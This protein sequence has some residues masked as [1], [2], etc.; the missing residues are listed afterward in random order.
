MEAAHQLVRVQVVAE[1]V[2]QL[3]AVAPLFERRHDRLDREALEA[4]QPAQR[5]LGLGLLDLQLALVGEH[6]PRHAGVLGARG[7]PLGAGLQ[8][9]QR[10]GVGV[11]ALALVHHRAHAV[12]G[13]GA[14]DEHHVA[15]LAQPRHA[16]AAVGERVD[17]QLQL[18]AA[19]GPGRIRIDG[20]GT[21]A[22]AHARSAG[23]A[24]RAAVAAAPSRSAASAISHSSSAFCAWRRFSACSQMR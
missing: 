5:I 23:T 14:G 4:A 7:D 11:V 6:L 10:A 24:R 20:G 13:D 9:L 8:D 3:V 16:L 15:V 17:G 2:L 1:G 12:A 18:L 21:I 19:L 22:G